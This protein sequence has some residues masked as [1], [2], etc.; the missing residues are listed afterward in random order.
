MVINDA[1]LVLCII[2]IMISRHKMYYFKIQT[3]DNTLIS[4][5]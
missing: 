3:N 5:R 1:D 2:L 4:M